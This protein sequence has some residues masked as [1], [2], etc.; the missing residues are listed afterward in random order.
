MDDPITAMF[1]ADIREA[2]ATVGL[3]ARTVSVEE[4]EEA[5]RRAWLHRGRRFHITVSATGHRTASSWWTDEQAARD[6]FA[7]VVAQ[8][9]SRPGARII[10]IDEVERT[11]VAAWPE[12]LSC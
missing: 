5:G 8:W 7:T 4:F 9:G 12:E 11:T 6:R 1:L 10:L 2:A 3:A